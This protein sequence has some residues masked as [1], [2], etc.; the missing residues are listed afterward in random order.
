MKLL[1][2]MEKKWEKKMVE[3]KNYPIKTQE[4]QADFFVSALSFLLAGIF[5]GSIIRFCIDEGWKISVVKSELVQ[6]NNRKI[7]KWH[8]TFH[9]RGE[10]LNAKNRR[11]FYER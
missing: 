7:E 2:K 1:K 6:L 8:S 4:L 9:L 5:I 10:I 11:V 3:C